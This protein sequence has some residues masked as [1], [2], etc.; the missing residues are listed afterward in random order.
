MT[1]TLALAAAANLGDATVVRLNGAGVVEIADGVRTTCNRLYVEGEEMPAGE[2]GA[3]ACPVFV[4]AHRRATVMAHFAGAGR[5]V[6][7]NGAAVA[8]GKKTAWTGGASAAKWSEAANWSNGVPALNDDVTLDVSAS[9]GGFAML[10][11]DLDGLILHSLTLTGGGSVVLTGR[12]IT[13]LGGGLTVGTDDADE[14]SVTNVIRLG[15]T[16]AEGQTWAIHGTRR[17]LH[18]EG[19]LDTTVVASALT[20]GGSGVWRL[21]ADLVGDGDVTL[22]KDSGPTYAAAPNCAFGS[23]KATLTIEGQSIYDT[24]KR[25]GAV[26]HLCGTVVSN[27]VVR[28][29]GYYA[30]LASG[31]RQCWIL[32]DAATRANVVLGELQFSDPANLCLCVANPKGQAA[33]FAGGCAGVKTL[34]PLS[35]F[36]PEQ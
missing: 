26:L 16:L 7:L 12:D 35:A 33:L 1:P 28:F 6:A 4:P 29:N 27:G 17:E 31:Q 19:T 32:S 10:D 21:F 18:H 20:R 5:L 9:G 24:S 30:R 3:T 36:A 13:L 25:G 14:T 2:Y 11:N 34:L 15:L 22:A 23:A 8:A